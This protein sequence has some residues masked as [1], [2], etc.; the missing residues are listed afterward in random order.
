METSAIS[1][2]RVSALFLERRCRKTYVIGYVRELWRQ[3]N[4]AD[5]QT[6]SRQRSPD[7]RKSS[8]KSRRRHPHQMPAVEEMSELG[9]D[10]KESSRSTHSPASSISE[11]GQS[12]FPPPSGETPQS[13]GARTPRGSASNP[14][15]L[16]AT[17]PSEL[18]S[19]SELRPYDATE[20]ASDVMVVCPICRVFQGDEASVT[21]HIE[22][23][24]GTL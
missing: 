17:P 10:D 9:I 18:P 13:P 20:G 15:E 7:P 14:S 22:E 2:K 19:A 12:A 16:C 23:H 1:H 6:V 24:V 11:T 5:H 4:T 21:F 8:L 3:S